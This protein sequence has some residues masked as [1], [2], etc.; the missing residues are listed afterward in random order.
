MD[1]RL[2]MAI[3]WYSQ[4]WDNIPEK[5]RIVKIPKRNGK[6]R[7]L[8]IPTII[9]DYQQRVIKEFLLENMLCSDFATAYRKGWNIRHTINNHTN[10]KLILKLD[11]KDFFRHITADLVKKE[12][13]DFE[14]VFSLQF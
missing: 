1:Y 13:F 5:Y 6:L 14:K 9:M 8:E 12:V 11:I 4:N 2:K 10:K 7:T 3:N